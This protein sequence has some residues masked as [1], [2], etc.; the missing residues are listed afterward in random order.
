MRAFAFTLAVLAAS[1]AAKHH[2]DDHSGDHS[3]HVDDVVEER[4][5][6]LQH[7]HDHDQD[8]P[9]NERTP[10]LSKSH[11][12]PYGSDKH[13]APLSSA[14]KQK[15]ADK[16]H[17]MHHTNKK[18]AFNDKH[19]HA[20]IHKKKADAQNKRNDEDPRSA[21]N[22]YAGYKVL[23]QTENQNEENA[24]D[25]KFVSNPRALILQA[26]KSGKTPA[27]IFSKPKYDDESPIAR[28]AWNTALEKLNMMFGV[29]DAKIAKRCS[30]T[31]SSSRCTTEYTKLASSYK[32]NVKPKLEMEHPPATETASS[33]LEFAYEVLA[34][35]GGALPVIS[36]KSSAS[37]KS[38]NPGAM[39]RFKAL[40]KAHAR[41]GGGCFDWL[42]P[43][44]RADAYRPHYDDDDDICDN[45][46]CTMIFGC[47]AACFAVLFY[48]L[49]GLFTG[50]GF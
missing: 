27:E 39:A 29:D 17:L 2:N 42:C 13:P 24:L 15:L 22:I 32:T 4:A 41:A 16:E 48:G 10:L 6:L 28:N 23:R 1:T 35:D 46:I 26:R 37:E 33:M 7:Q 14:E 25:E 8:T 5:P 30:R 38:S 21:H 12:L 50:I 31:L 47:F 20:I 45:P 40:A 44:K 9:V 43:E 19:G 49:P 18:N 36:P 3:H 34:V 11:G